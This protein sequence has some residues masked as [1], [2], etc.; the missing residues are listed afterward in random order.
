MLRLLQYKTMGLQDTFRSLA[1]TA[2]NAFGNIAQT[3][4]YHSAGA[5]TVTAGVV[6]RAVIA[7]AEVKVIASDY[8][9]YEISASQGEIITSDQQFLV[10]SLSLDTIVPKKS[11][12]IV[13]A[14]GASWE[15]IN[16][17]LDEAGALYALQVR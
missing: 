1:V 7:T 10:P 9:R 16:V 17:A 12:W 3:V 6:T 2:V 5:A 13:D 15:V 11:D 14:T 4:T 8:S